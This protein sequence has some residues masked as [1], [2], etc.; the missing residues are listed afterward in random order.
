MNAGGGTLYSSKL[1]AI[2]DKLTRVADVSKIGTFSMDSLRNQ[3]K[4]RLVS[5]DFQ[6]FVCVVITL[7]WFSLVVMGAGGSGLGARAAERTTRSR[8]SCVC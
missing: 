8:R 2:V 3:R 4:C 5:G 6:G 7:G 1:T